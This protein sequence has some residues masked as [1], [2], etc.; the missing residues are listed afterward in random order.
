VTGVQSA[1]GFG[2]RQRPRTSG[3]RIEG[4]V[5]FAADRLRLR[6]RSRVE[7][8]EAPHSGLLSTQTFIM[9]A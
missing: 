9:E 4:S 3:W 1:S 8:I 5:R 7:G 6:L 2:R